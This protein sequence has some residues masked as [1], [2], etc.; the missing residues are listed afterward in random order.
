MSEENVEI[1]R[2]SFDAFNRGEMSPY[3]D[4]NVVVPPEGWPEGGEI[5]GLAEFFHSPAEALEAAG[6]SQ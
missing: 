2:A 1:V 4:A 6:L 3:V 5:R